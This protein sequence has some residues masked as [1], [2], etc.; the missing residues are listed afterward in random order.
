M[1]VR[2]A[3]EDLYVGKGGYTKIAEGDYMVKVPDDEFTYLIP[4]NYQL[5]GFKRGYAEA[6]K[7]G[8]DV[9]QAF[10]SEAFKQGIKTVNDPTIDKYYFK[11]SGGK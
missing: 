9:L 7:A 6:K 11:K 2:T 10:L 1:K 5:L 4:N 8:P 3:F